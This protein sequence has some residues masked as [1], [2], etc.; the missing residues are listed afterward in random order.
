MNF[1]CSLL[2][3]ATI[4]VLS[5]PS[6]MALVA[7]AVN[8]PTRFHAEAPKSPRDGAAESSPLSVD[9]FSSPSPS[10][11]PSAFDVIRSEFIAPLKKSEADLDIDDVDDAVA[12]SSS[13]EGFFP[14]SSAVAVVAAAVAVAA[15]A[16]T[17]LTAEERPWLVLDSRE[18]NDQDEDEDGGAAVKLQMTS[19]KLYSHY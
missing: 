8:W 10:P 17:L 7:P 1:C 6:L 2:N 5:S 16:E 4:A 19:L 9:F 14:E 12:V 3:S 18:P 11:S 13:V 15:A